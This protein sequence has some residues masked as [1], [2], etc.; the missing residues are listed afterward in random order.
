MT[1]TPL[2][3]SGKLGLFRQLYPAQ[4]AQNKKQKEVF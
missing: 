2:P 1:S 4:N 3:Q